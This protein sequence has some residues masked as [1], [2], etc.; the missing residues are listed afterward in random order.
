MARKETRAGRGR[1]GLARD[2]HG[3]QGEGNRE[4]DRRYREGAKRFVESG[5]VDEA[6]RDARD[7]LE[8]EAEP[9]DAAKKRREERKR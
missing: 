9:G 1:E 8:A 4:A 6:A 7:S 5:R 2:I 3:V